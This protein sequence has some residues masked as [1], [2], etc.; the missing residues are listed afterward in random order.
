MDRRQ[1]VG[2]TG[3]VALGVTAQ[4]R[5]AIPARHARVGS[6]SVTAWGQGGAEMLAHAMAHGCMP[7][8]TAQDL[9]PDAAAELLLADPFEPGVAAAVVDAI[10]AARQDGRRVLAVLRRQR[11]GARRYGRAV[12]E[13]RYLRI[14]ADVAVVVQGRTQDAGVE[15]EGLL[16]PFVADA[17]PC[18]DPCDLDEAVR[19]GNAAAVGCGSGLRV[20]QAMQAA[21][22]HPAL[23]LS[24][25]AAVDEVLVTISG[26][27]GRMLLSESAEAF[28]SLRAA[29]PDARMAFARLPG[30]P[31]SGQVWVHI[32]AFGPAGRIVQ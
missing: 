32:V 9:L 21:I 3:A 7:W 29:V 14:A 26:D 27:W 23:G 12:A 13:A 10:R 31:E 6:A 17:M 2:M 15:W 1:F 25:A 19:N 8:A 11:P 24:R 20:Q 22:G 4:A 30:P 16:T 18:L 28:R 5:A